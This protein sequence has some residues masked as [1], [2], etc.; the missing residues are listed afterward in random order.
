MAKVKM[1]E[2][3]NG[4]EVQ[5][6]QRARGEETPYF[7]AKILKDGVEVGYASNNGRGG[8]TMIRGGSVR[9][10]F[11]GLI[12]EAARA[13]GIVPEESL[14]KWEPEGVVLTYALCKGYDR[15]CGQITLN[16]FVQMYAR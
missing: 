7:Q 4:Y 15:G 14:L 16:N 13:V 10:D 1:I 8:A 5:F 2:V 3:G 9:E 12:F 11:K 6:L